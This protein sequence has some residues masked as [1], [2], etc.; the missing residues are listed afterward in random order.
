MSVNSS[1]LSRITRIMIAAVLGTMLLA[2]ALVVSTSDRAD[3]ADGAVKAKRTE[4]LGADASLRGALCPENCSALAIV[5]GF[6]AGI[7]GAP[8]PYRVPFNGKIVKWMISLGKPTSSQRN[9][10]EQRFGV[11]PKAG[12]GVVRPV[13]VAG[14][15]QY[16]LVKRS[17]VIGLNRYLGKVAP[18][19]LE[20]SVR[21]KKGDYVVLTVPTWAPALASKTLPNP[22]NPNR[23]LPDTG[24]NWRASRDRTVCGKTPNMKNSQPQTKLKSK[25]YY[26]CKFSSAQLLYRVKITS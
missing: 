14:R 4:V 25:V 11:K 26:G 16:K 24:Y 1:G 18:I 5:S 10:F 20:K 19:K 3:A 17:P 22:A 21:V 23:P 2:G 13:T 15:K 12:I 8:N 6:Q 9:F 7:D